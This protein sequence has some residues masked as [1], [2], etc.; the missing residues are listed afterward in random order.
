MCVYVCM[1]SG[2]HENKEIVSNIG[3][4]IKN[5]L[6]CTYTPLSL[7][8]YQFTI[9]AHDFLIFIH[10]AEL[11]VPTLPISEKVWSPLLFRK[12]V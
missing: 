6:F 10:T 7:I 8:S 9:I 12:E 4:L 5:I 3:K 1:H 2:V 11:A